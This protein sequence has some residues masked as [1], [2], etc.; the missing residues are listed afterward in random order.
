VAAAFLSKSVASW[1]SYRLRA[2]LEL[3]SLGVTVL[4]CLLVGRLVS[5]AGSGFDER[6]GMGYAAFAL[7][8][9]AV[10]GAASAGLRTFRSSVRREQLQG[11]LEHLLASP[12]DPALVIVLSVAGELCLSAVGGLA[13]LFVVSKAA[14]LG[15]VLT[16]GVLV[17]IILYAAAMSGLGLASAGVVLVHK[18]GEPVSWALSSL[19]GLLGGVAFPVELLP[20]WLRCLSFALPTTHALSLV[21]SALASGHL[22]QNASLAALVWAAALLPPLGV[23]S[24]RSA[25]RRVTRDGSLGHY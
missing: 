11:T 8:G 10:H 2:A 25:L 6:F 20:E 1:L 5:S 16:A 12:L 22:A 21:R 19:T 24:L 13:F 18:E 9:L 15:H 7:V 17:P 14:G 3:A 23:V 4:S